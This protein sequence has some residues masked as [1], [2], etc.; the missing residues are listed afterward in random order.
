MC[1]PHDW[2]WI[3]APGVA[4]QWYQKDNLRTSLGICYA[5]MPHIK[6]KESLK[7]KHFCCVHVWQLSHN[8]IILT[9]LSVQRMMKLKVNEEQRISKANHRAPF[10]SVVDNSSK[11]IFFSLRYFTVLFPVTTDHMLCYVNFVSVLNTSCLLSIHF[12]LWQGRV[13]FS[14]PAML[15]EFTMTHFT[16]F[17]SFSNRWTVT[18]VNS[19]KLIKNVISPKIRLS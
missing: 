19:E 9:Y 4:I 2:R 3:D 13:H 17:S 10:T 18:F 11:L 16:V 1:P 12:V 5:P 15:T 14:N 7:G 8:K 6:L